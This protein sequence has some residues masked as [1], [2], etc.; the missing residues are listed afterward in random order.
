MVLKLITMVLADVFVFRKLC[1][2][3][4][5]FSGKVKLNNTIP[6]SNFSEFFLE[7]SE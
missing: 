5:K 7:N 2:Y 3:Y 6:V 4:S 1:Q